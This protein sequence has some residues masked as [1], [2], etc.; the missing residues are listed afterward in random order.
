MNYRDVIQQSLD[1]IEEN[2]RAGLTVEELAQSAGFSVYHFYRLFHKHTGL[3]VMQYI[4]RRRLLHAIYAV[5]NGQTRIEAALMYGFDTYPGFY[6]AFRREFGCT[7]SAFLRKNRAKR[8]ARIDL[9][10]EDNMKHA[11]A[12]EVLKHWGMENAAVADWYYESSGSR[13]DCALRIGDAYVLKK[14]ASPAEVQK[15]YHLAE[16]LKKTGLKTPIPVSTIS[17]ALYVEQDGHCYCLYHQPE[18]RQM[19]AVSFYGAGGSEKARFVGEMLGQLHRTLQNESADIQESDLLENVQK[20][21]L[22]KAAAILHLSP[23]FC[24][25]YLARFEQF[26]PLLPR[27]VIH[28]NPN[29]GSLL[30]GDESWGVMDL[31]M[32]ERNVRLFDPCYAA[33]AILSESFEAQQHRRNEWLNVY[34]QLMAGYDAVAGLTQ[35]E[36]EA[37]PYVLLANQLICTAW[38]AD[39]PHLAEV[40]ETNVHM[41]RWIISRLEALKL[42]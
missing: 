22:P 32:A 18:E 21:A 8:P 30:A 42:E 19:T 31:E 17:G 24:Q 5:R 16:R 23:A 35:A 33:T 11:E 14:A 36:K 38:F 2:L 39:Q 41:T 27:Q 20:W 34:H 29:P 13:A 10:R 3:P 6:K 40:F 4:Q 7:P 15:V 1:Y 12:Q 37:A 25:E 9:T 26:H 28:R